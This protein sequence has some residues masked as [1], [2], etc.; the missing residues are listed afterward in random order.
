MERPILND[1]EI[2]PDEDVLKQAL[3]EAYFA[4]SEFNDL[5]TCPEN[6]LTPI[7]NYYKDGKSWL[8][9]VQYK[10][11]TVFWLSVWPGYFNTTF[12]FTE[13]HL[14]SFGH[15]PVNESYKAQLATVPRIGKLIPL[16]IQISD[17]TVFDD[18]S[19]IIDFKK[20]LK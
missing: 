19:I 14:E 10:N 11:K 7:W 9:K 12:Y 15:L 1:P 16:T 5:I 8:C 3:K 17:K 4:Y 18:L 2:L 20:R 6:G 13:K